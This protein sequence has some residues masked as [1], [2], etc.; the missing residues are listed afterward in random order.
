M[1]SIPGKLVSTSYYLLVS[2]ELLALLPGSAFL[3]T[4]YYDLYGCCERAKVIPKPLINPLT[5]LESLRGTEAIL[6]LLLHSCV[7]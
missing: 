5:S 6:P 2:I 1:V 4:V 7:P 3:G